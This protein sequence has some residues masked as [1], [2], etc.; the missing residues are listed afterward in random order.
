[1]VFEKSLFERLDSGDQM[2]IHTT[3]VDTS[4]VVDSIRRHLVNLFNTREGNSMGAPEYGMPDFN[5]AAASHA[6]FIKQIRTSIEKIIAENESRLSNVNVSYLPDT[7][8]PLDL[9]FQIIADVNIEGKK[10]N[11]SF[12]VSLGRGPGTT[13]MRN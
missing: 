8:R 6:D 11:T 12:D 10:Q 7:E 13:K 1:M 5:D 9:N 2:D 3:K 4:A